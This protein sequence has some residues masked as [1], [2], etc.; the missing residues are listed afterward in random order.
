MRRTPSRRN[1]L[2]FDNRIPLTPELRES[3]RAS[4][5]RVA[6]SVLSPAK[7]RA[8]E[9]ATA[10]SPHNFRIVIS[11]HYRTS[12]D[13][14]WLANRERLWQDVV[15]PN[16]VTLVSEWSARD[17]LAEAQLFKRTEKAEQGGVFTAFTYLHRLGDNIA[18]SLFLPWVFNKDDLISTLG[19]GYFL[20]LTDALEVTA[21]RADVAEIIELVRDNNA[22]LHRVA[23]SVTDGKDLLIRYIETHVN[24]KMVREGY[25]SE[26][27]Q[28]LADLF[29]LC[30][31]TPPSRPL[32]L[33]FDRARMSMAYPRLYR[34]YWEGDYSASAVDACNY[35]GEEMNVRFRA[36]YN[37]LIPALYG[38]V[39]FI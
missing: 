13:D 15:R 6:A 29:P 8:I 21:Q 24:S 36:L 20:H 5:A 14:L 26:I 27:G 2:T 33:P 32:F 28:S 18:S 9:A 12:D 39:W 7:H 4:K 34:D 16:A 1:P 11:P 17:V 19:R 10:N 30:E 35:Y 38:T 23:N 22:L 37:T 3:I 31:F 25:S